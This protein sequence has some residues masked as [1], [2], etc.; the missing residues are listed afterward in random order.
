MTGRARVALALLATFV[1]APA[2]F[3]APPPA[4][5]AAP[6]AADGGATTA[7]A[8]PAATEPSCASA[9]DA[10]ATEAGPPVMLAI[11]R[12]WRELGLSDAQLDR[13]KTVA[14]GFAR[15]AI[16]R[17]AEIQIAQLDLAML[18]APDPEDPAKAS[19]VAAA[20]AKI[21][22][23]AKMSADL[24]IAGLRAVEAGKAVLTADQRAAL[25][26]L[27]AGEAPPAARGA[28]ATSDAARGA[29]D[30]PEA[31]RA[32]GDPPEGARGTGSR[33]AA[34]HGAPSPGAP[35]HGAPGAHARP[36]AHRPDIHRHFAPRVRPFVGVTPWFWWEPYWPPEVLVVPP[37]AYV[38]QPRYW[39]YCPSAGAYW[40]TVPSCP[41]PWVPVL[42]G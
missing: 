29:G 6:P 35:P 2:A 33:G 18:L 25:A 24:E 16:R 10:G 22:E 3:A 38:P 31:A 15:E 4:P 26:A 7:P 37:P 9:P 42:A 36:P 20:E 19:D 17:Q 34:P 5:P 32:A 11:V 8:P 27:L 23:I 40:P 30:P 39:Y 1:L 13:L 41:E 12:C 28:G 14:I 21:Q